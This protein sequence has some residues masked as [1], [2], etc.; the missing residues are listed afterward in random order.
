MSSKKNTRPPQPRQPLVFHVLSPDERHCSTKL[1]VEEPQSL[2][3][4]DVRV[5]SRSV[6]AVHL[7]LTFLKLCW[8][9]ICGLSCWLVPD[10]QFQW[11]F[12]LCF[13]F[14]TNLH[15]DWNDT[16]LQKNTLLHSEAFH[17]P[18]FVWLLLFSFV[19][20][21]T[22]TNVIPCCIPRRSSGPFLFVSVVVV[23]VRLLNTKTEI[24]PYCIPRR[25]SGPSPQ[26]R[27]TTGWWPAC[28]DRPRLCLYC[29]HCVHCVHCQTINVKYKI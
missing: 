25:S 27:W 15:K 2:A 7:R 4:L 9:V 5:E 3:W 22:K 17:R 28:T 14:I 8:V 20:Y 12:F 19:D 16:L 1:V 23:F 11:S 29:V 10:Q 24:I 21:H 6:G 13:F 18:F 26:P